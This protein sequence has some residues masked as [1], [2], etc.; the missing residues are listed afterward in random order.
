MF[1]K[2]FFIVNYLLI[3]VVGSFYYYKI[4]ESKPLRLF[5]IFLVYSLVTEILGS[6]TAYS[7]RPNTAYIYNIWNFVS[8]LFFSYFFL[9][10]IK[11]KW[12]RLIIYFFALVVVILFIVNAFFYQDFFK[13]V[14]RYHKMLCSIFICIVI[15]MYFSEILMSD[16][17]LNFKKSMSFWIALG[18]F[19]ME[20]G[21]IP[22]FVIGE[23]IEYRG[24]F[25][26]IIFL[27]NIL[28][29]A[30]FIIGFVVSK[31]EFNTNKIQ[32]SNG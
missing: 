11:T 22:I 8:Y 21:I 23:L 20:I 25:R 4:R 12:K 31:K 14:F 10:Y 27:L 5:F 29:G 3:I 26:Y 6:Y 17:I 32:K 18:V 13:D 16:L 19:I 7:S 2:Y 28:M 24:V 1:Q 30:S 15:V 9:N